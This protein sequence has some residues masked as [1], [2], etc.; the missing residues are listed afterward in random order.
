MDQTT[1][2]KY[3]R[4]KLVTSLLN[5]GIELLFWLAVIFAGIAEFFAVLA[6]HYTTHPLLQFYLFA[7]AL[8]IIHTVVNFPLSFYSGYVIEHR[9][10]LSNQ[11]VLR[12][13]GE[14]LKG[15]GVGL[16]LGAILMTVFYLLLWQFPETWWIGIWLFIL[17]FSILLTRLAPILLFPL[18]YKFTPIENETLTEKIHQIARR[19]NLNITGIF[20]FNLSKT[21]KK[22]NAAFTG[23]GKS[24]RVIL[25]DTLLEN[26]HEEEIETVF[27]H[28]V[29]HY[30][31][32]HLIKGIILNILLSLAGIYIVFQIYNVIIASQNVAPHHLTALPYLGLLFLI[33][34]LITGPVGNLVSR[35]FEYQADRFAV[36][37][38]GKTD[39]FKRSLKK[40][41]Q[42]N[43][44]DESPHPLVEF[45][46]YSHPSIGHRIEKISGEQS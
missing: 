13:A 3:N 45:L 30:L 1:V 36:Q 39:I 11:T 46:F 37:T 35:R 20:Q 40:L 17:I 22:A 27:A 31:Q 10:S 24:K 29:G 26:F 32:K 5:L 43:L 23:L 16:I 44:A 21:T 33:Y 25:A 18:F 2:K 8:G 41:S 15:L 14:Q 34:G 28:E 38:T 6:A 7:V 12:W 4:L 42:L 19:W 9:F